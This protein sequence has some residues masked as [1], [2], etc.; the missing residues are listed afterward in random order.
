VFLL[1][2]SM[3]QNYFNGIDSFEVT[4]SI[5]KLPYYVH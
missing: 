3:G 1:I 4:L 2:L 5:V